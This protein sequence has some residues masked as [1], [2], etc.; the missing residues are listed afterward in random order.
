[1]IDERYVVLIILGG[2]LSYD[3]LLDARRDELMGCTS[4]DMIKDEPNAEE[5]LNGA[6]LLTIS[7]DH[8]NIVTVVVN[9]RQLLRNGDAAAALNLLDKLFK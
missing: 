2:K 1:M 3:M 9:A 8:A 4:Y 7:Q 6:I 5:V